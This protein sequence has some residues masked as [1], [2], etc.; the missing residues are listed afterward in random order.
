MLLSDTSWIYNRCTLSSLS[1]WMTR[2]DTALPFW[3]N[4][5]DYLSLLMG[6]S[7]DVPLFDD[8]SVL[9]YVW[10]DFVD[11]AAYIQGVFK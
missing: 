7:L 8:L 1:L 5:V 3:K 4:S 9:P 2:D 10:A 6:L 11:S